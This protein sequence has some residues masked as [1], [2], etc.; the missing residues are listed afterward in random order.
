MKKLYVILPLALILCFMVGCQQG[1]EVAEEPVLKE[2]FPIID[3]HVHAYSALKGENPSWFPLDLY[4]PKTDEELMNE[5]LKRFKQFNIVKVVAFGNKIETWKDAAPELILTGWQNS[6]AGNTDKHL[7]ALKKDIIDGRIDVIGEILAQYAGL[8]P[9]DPMLEPYYAL[10]EELDVPIGIHMGPG[11]PGYAYSDAPNYRM[12]QG[13]PLH[14][15]DILVKHPK[16]RLYVMHAGW[17][18]LDEMVAIMFFY[19]NVYVDISAINWFSP[20]D[21][22]HFYLRRLIQAGFGKRIMFGS[23]QM[24]W[25]EA[26]E[27]AIESVESADFL[28]EEQKRDIFY[29]N[30]VRFFRLEE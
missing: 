17:P 5:N 23:D 9:N 21:D 1:E 4:A 13:R 19:P 28:T 11:P 24:F 16:L 25:P 3:V 18:L 10:A 30:A 29:N 7:A 8:A 2:R 27:V 20:R 6:I 26:I 14:L 22:F 12:R 15:E